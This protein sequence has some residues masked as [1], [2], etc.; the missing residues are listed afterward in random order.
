MR[1]LLLGGT[2]DALAIARTLDKPHVY[3]LAGLA[4][5]RDW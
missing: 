5:S 3:S 1:M 2:G 4:V